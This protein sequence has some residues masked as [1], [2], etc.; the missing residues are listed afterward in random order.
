M[1]KKAW[2]LFLSISVI[3]FLAVYFFWPTYE[4][5]PVLGSV[6]NF[7]L[8]NVQGS[9]YEL[10]SEKVKIVTF[11]Y[12][13]CP[14]VCPMTIVDLTTLQA[15]LQNKGVFGE[16]V[17]LVAISLDPENDTAE[18]IQKYS[19]AFNTDPAGWKWVRGTED[20]TKEIAS[21]FNMQYQ[22]LEG[23]FFSH[24]ITMYLLDEKNQIRALY[25]MANANDPLDTTQ[26]LEDISLLIPSGF[27][28]QTP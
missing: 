5:L 7:Q 8:Q 4:K 14:D 23:D 9:T 27:H 3:G 10:N 1:T 13:R 6:S 15:E 24:S 19:Q 22:K 20:E 21:R 17:E 12:T 26:I 25:D 28:G 11:F 16:Q 2:G 18:A